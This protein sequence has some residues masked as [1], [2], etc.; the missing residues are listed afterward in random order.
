MM[1]LTNRTDNTIT[2]MKQWWQKCLAVEFGHIFQ[3]TYRFTQ[4]DVEAEKFGKLICRLPNFSEFQ[5]LANL[6]IVSLLI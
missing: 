4:F 3:H 2:R 1:T 6:G 5:H